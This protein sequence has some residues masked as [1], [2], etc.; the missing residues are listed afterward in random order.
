MP[1]NYSSV[2][3]ALHVLCKFQGATST[4]KVTVRLYNVRTVHL[5]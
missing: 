2:H 4:Q 3:S 1:D 5:H